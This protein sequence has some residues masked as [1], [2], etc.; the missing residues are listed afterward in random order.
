MK[1]SLGKGLESLIPKKIEEIEESYAV[2]K[3]S[4]FYIEINKIK[5][6]PYQPRQEFN[7]KSIDDLAESVREYGILQPLIVTR[8]GKGSYQLVAGERR[9]MAA[10]K[11][12]LAQVPVIIREPTKK[13]KLEVALVENVQRV[14]LNAMEKAEAFKKLQ[15][16]FSLTQKD[17]GQLM[18]MSREA[19]TN[20]LRL[21]DLPEEVKQALRE[22]K[23]SEG[24]ARSILPIKDPKK[25][26]L[27]LEKIIK[28][29]LN[30]R[31]VETIAQK[32]GEWKHTKR[33]VSDKILAE[34]K[35]FEQDF[36][37]SLGVTDA[38]LKMEAGKPKLIIFF[39]SKKEMTEMLAKLKK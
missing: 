21:L 25:Q 38:R 12:G 24:H 9:L 13:E 33:K 10:K 31:E 34:V 36:R 4:I 8:D 20:T 18:G 29:G 37:D 5:P 16:E 19:V 35:S 15:A 1:N 22:K 11:I 14:N 3:E 6:N 17:I 7:D 23:I 30:V 28:E 26:K 32:I 27:I 39:S 2:K